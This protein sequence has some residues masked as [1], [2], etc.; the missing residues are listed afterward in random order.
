MEIG[1]CLTWRGASANGYGSSW[2][3]VEAME[4]DCRYRRGRKAIEG[5]GER[6]RREREI[7]EVRF[8]RESIA[9]WLAAAQRMN[10]QI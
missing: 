5:R 1:A 9:G 2:G 6:E 7:E 4:S 3:R 10:R 8:G